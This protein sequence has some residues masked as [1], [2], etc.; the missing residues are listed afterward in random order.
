MGLSGIIKRGMIYLVQ[1]SDRRRAVVN[2]GNEL[3]GS[4]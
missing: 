4:I 3:S 2:V 1:D